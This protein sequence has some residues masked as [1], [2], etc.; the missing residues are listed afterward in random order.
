M[1]KCKRKASSTSRADFAGRFLHFFS[2]LLTFPKKVRI[3]LYTGS[4]Q[5]SAAGHRPAVCCL[6]GAFYLKSC[7]IR[8]LAR[9]WPCHSECYT[10]TRLPPARMRI[11]MISKTN[12][13][14]RK[15]LRAWELAWASLSQRARRNA[16]LL[17]GK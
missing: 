11:Y 17:R 7:E 12:T 6:G 3:V 1:N 2:F 4:Q 9:G 13:A 15:T 5:A 8:V 10:V 14:L 16:L